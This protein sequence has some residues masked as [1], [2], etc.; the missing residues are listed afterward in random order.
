MC[1]IFVDENGNST[2]KRFCFLSGLPRSGST[3]LSALLN[4]HPEI[5]ASTNSP[6]LDLIHFTEDYLLNRS[7]Q[8]KAH[9]RPASAQR[10]ISSLPANYYFDIAESVIVDKSRSWVHQIEHIRD[11]ITDEPRI[12]CP[13]RDIADIVV[14]F[15]VLLASGEPD[16]YIDTAVRR[17]GQQPST[18][19]R[20]SFLM[21]PRGT[22][23]NPYLAMREAYQKGWD[24]Y[25]LIIEYEDLVQDPQSQMDRI[26][27]FIGVA[28]F[29][30]NTNKVAAAF[31]E[32]D[33]AYGLKD[34]HK[35]R[36]RVE[37]IERNHTDYLPGRL[38]RKCRNL[39]FW[40]E[41]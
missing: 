34:M 39:E 26:Y 15:L 31:D 28:S 12:I 22:I 38:L 6:L 17:R 9:P 1:P 23:G 8:Y 41:I 10:V 16:N 18:E 40:R 27:D 3:L 14:S 21:E 7:E 35:V 4:Q 36:S 13:V 2:G 37:K 11:Y 19:S 32:D 25:L 24:R 20:V 29:A 30:N 33:S 5:H